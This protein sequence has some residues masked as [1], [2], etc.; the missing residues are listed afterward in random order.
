MTQSVQIMTSSDL[1]CANFVLF[2]LIRDHN[3]AVHA[4]R[5]VL[6]QERFKLG[7]MF[8]Q[9]RLHEHAS[10]PAGNPSLFAREKHQFRYKCIILFYLMD[11]DY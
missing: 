2:S 10:Q 5:A 9:I 11:I 7:P 1:N 3:E 8:L 6:L 4:Q